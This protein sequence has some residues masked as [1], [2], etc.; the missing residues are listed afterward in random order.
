M[1]FTFLLLVREVVNGKEK[2]KK[3]VV[4]AGRM[5]ERRVINIYCCP[6]R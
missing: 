3:D 2:E 4:I 1:T 5:C 6:Y